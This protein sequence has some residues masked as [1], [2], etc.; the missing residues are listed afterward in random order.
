MRDSDVVMEFCS[1]LHPHIYISV[2]LG[3]IIKQNLYFKPNF[4]PSTYIIHD[5]MLSS[6]ITLLV[7]VLLL[8]SILGYI[9]M[10]KYHSNSGSRNSS[11][12]FCANMY[13]LSFYHWKFNFHVPKMYAAL[14]IVTKSK[15]AIFL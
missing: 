13:L 8:L 4:S 15:V 9:I 10:D 6:Y 1:S 2:Q 5:T 12:H 14:T 11:C 7:L 3:R